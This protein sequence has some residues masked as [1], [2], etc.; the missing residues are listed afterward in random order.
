[1]E[2][3]GSFRVLFVAGFDPIVRDVAASRELY[4]RGLGISF[5]EETGN[6]LH[7]EALPGAKTFALW[8]LA[9]AARSCFGTT[10]W[11]TDV[12]VPHAWIEFDVDDL[13][14]ATLELEARRYPML[15]KNRREPWG[16]TVSRFLSPDG[17]LLAVTV[18]P[19]LRQV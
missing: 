2:R 19:S 14:A 15:V 12:P 8:P 6:Y 5:K 16:Q 3:P 18:T 11:P 13:V 1:M 7:T 4:A 10:A 9:E 17:L